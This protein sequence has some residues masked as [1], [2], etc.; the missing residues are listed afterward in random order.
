MTGQ[1]GLEAQL[2]E[3]TPA[4]ACARRAYAHYR[5]RQVAKLGAPAERDLPAAFDFLPAFRQDYYLRMG[6]AAILT[7]HLPFDEV[8]DAVYRAGGGRCG[9]AQLQPQGR[10]HWR[11]IVA[12]MLELDFTP[13]KEPS[14]AYSSPE[15]GGRP[16]S[17]R[18]SGRGRRSQRPPEP[19][20]A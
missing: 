4:Q 14:D 1:I 19:P 15:E 20:G 9:M 10:N 16:K 13:E 7:A 11:G 12:A 8:V 3:L 5:G 17:S 2:D 18:R 6:D